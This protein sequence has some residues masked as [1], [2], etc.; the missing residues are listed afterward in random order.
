ML[1]VALQLPAAL[2]TL[3]LALQQALDEYEALQLQIHMSKAGDKINTPL[4]SKLGALPPLC[5]TSSVLRLISSHL[6]QVCDCSTKAIP[7]PVACRAL[8][9]GHPACN[10]LGLACP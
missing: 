4:Q 8:Q 1:S 10:R 9:G 5:S 6:L 2:Q 7:L 3:H